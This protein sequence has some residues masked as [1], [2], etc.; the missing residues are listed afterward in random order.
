M[1]MLQQTTTPRVVT[2]PQENISPVAK[3]A[4]PCRQNTLRLGG[5]VSH[6][7]EIRKVRMIFRGHREVGDSRRARYRYLQ[8]AKQPPQT[9]VHTT[10]SKPRMGYMP[11]L[12]D[13][14]FTQANASWVHHP[15]KDALVITVEVANSLVHRLLVDNRSAVNILYLDAC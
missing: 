14:V 15:H 11:Q 4:P 13:I 12:D 10:G 1:V 2:R 8:K 9:V 5:N 6:T 7:P 3:S